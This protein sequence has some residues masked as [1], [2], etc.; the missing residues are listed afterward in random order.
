MKKIIILALLT[1][2]LLQAKELPKE[3]DL[4]EGT[5]PNG[6]SYTI[7]HNEKPKDFVEFRL[8]VDAGSLEEEDDQRGLAH[9]IEH[10]AFNGTKHFKKNELISYLESIGLKFGG[11]LNANTGFT[12]TLYKLSVPVK[13][14][15]I[16]TALTVLDDWAGGLLFNPE[17]FDKERGVVLEEKRLRNSPSFRLYQQYAPLFYGESKYKDRIVIGKEEVL[18]HVPVQRAV[19]FYQKWYRPELMHLVVVGD[20]NVTEME[21]QIK[22]HFSGLENK[23]HEKPISRLI[24]ENNSTRIMALTDKEL[25]QNT[26]EVYYLERVFGTHTKAEKKRDIMTWMAQMMFN[27]EAKKELLKAESKALDIFAM[28]QTLTPY[29]K[30]YLF[31]AAYREKDRQEAFSQLYRL[32][33][34]FEKFGFDVRTFEQVKKQLLERN[35]NAHKAIHTTDSG[36]L[37]SELV[38]SIEHDAVF[39]DR[40]EDYKIV[41]ALAQEITP[42]EVNDRF[43]EIVNIPDRVILF[44]STTALTVNKE[45]VLQSIKLSK[46]E[47]KAPLIKKNKTLKLLKKP[48]QAKKIVKKDFDKET[49]IYTYILENNVTVLFKPTTFRQNEVLLSAVSPGGL[50]AL[51]TEVLND[52]KKASGWVMQSAPGNLKPDELRTLLADKSVRVDFRLSRFDEKIDGRS[53]SK[54]LETLL[55]L[56]YVYA[57]APK[58][59]PGVDRQLRNSALALALQSDRDPAYK[60]DKA[61]KKF[62]YMDNPRILFDTKESIT[63]LNN[64]KMLKLFKEKFDDMNHFTFMIVGDTQ[65]EAVERLIAL[66]LA[67]LPTAS[68][69]EK[70]NTKPFA[71]KKGKQTFVRAF[72]TSNIA[73]TGLKYRSELDY[74]MHDD[75]VLSVMQEILNVRLRNLIRED[76]SG[77]YGVGIKCGIIREL[78]KTASCNIRFASDPTRENE[79]VESIQKSIR[80]FIK[81][82]PTSQELKNIQTEYA[83]M[84]KKALRDNYFWLGLMNDH[85]KF[86][87]DIKTRLKFNEEIKKVTTEEV[88]K[89]AKK[90]FSGDL[91][92]SERTPQ[93]GSK[94]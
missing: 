94:K 88:R 31:K 4:A 91:L 92:L 52:A 85:A 66:Y 86:N 23:K 75:I 22:A 34:R 36:K 8:I 82:G 49:G 48:L 15:N 68:S 84:Y 29:K 65:P 54:D 77:T 73:N 55:S 79:L 30:A 43:K 78:E 61:L 89:M 67:N 7:L 40:E 63:A 72:N 80:T 47:A 76:K 33:W 90:M 27:L 57:T 70:I 74:S 41:K 46:K 64:E 17:E 10:M 32:M 18:K 3:K 62:Y 87:D 81:E 50:S 1:A 28:T 53:N 11:D 20:V 93:K 42:E 12:R 16:D 39:V 37:A 59:D 9:F 45:K 25:F 69:E 21:A 13:E 60:F 44:K 35:E 56:V 19:D 24:A 26:V 14:K 2:L 71:Y 58:I 51:P 83:L 38:S 6:F 5:L